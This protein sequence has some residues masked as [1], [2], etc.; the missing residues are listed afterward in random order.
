MGGALAAAAARART[1]SARDDCG[2][3]AQGCVP[4]HLRARIPAR[5]W[6]DPR[7]YQTRKCAAREGPR[8]R[9]TRGRRRRRER[10]RAPAHRLW[11][12]LP[13]GARARLSRDTGPSVSSVQS[14]G[15]AFW[16]GVW[17]RGGLL[18]RG[19]CARG[20]LPAPH[21]LLGPLGLGAG[22]ADVRGFRIRASSTP[23][24][25]RSARSLYLRRR[26]RGTRS[27]RRLAQ[28]AVVRHPAGPERGRRRM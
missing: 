24:C 5:T 9:G 14:P 1:P 6:A 11:Q 22:P 25:G 15:G 26:G 21:A 18:E 10:A 4:A 13:R 19:H 27:Q 28:P 12:R 7:R 20:A 17:L 23:V 8:S 16:I 3:H 2:R